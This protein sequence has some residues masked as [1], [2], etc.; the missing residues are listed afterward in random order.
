MSGKSSL[1]QANRRQ[2]LCLVW[3]NRKKISQIINAYLY[4]PFFLLIILWSLPSCKGCII[5]GIREAMSWQ[6]RHPSVSYWTSGNHAVA[7]NGLGFTGHILVCISCI[8]SHTLDSCFNSSDAAKSSNTHRAFFHNVFRNFICSCTQACL[9]L[10]SLCWINVGWWLY[11]IFFCYLRQKVSSTKRCPLKQ[12]DSVHQA[13]K[14]KN[15]TRRN[16]FELIEE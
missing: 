11:I 9:L 5:F 1:D 14:L 15:K 2:K 3:R 6:I 12:G 8:S 4:L 13:V 16:F 7:C 10:F